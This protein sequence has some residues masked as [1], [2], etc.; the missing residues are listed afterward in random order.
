MQCTARSVAAPPALYATGAAS[1]TFWSIYKSIPAAGAAMKT[2]SQE[3]IQR[4]AATG[5]WG[6]ETLHGLLARNAGNNPDR[7]ALKD[8][9]DRAELTGSPPRSLS[10]RELEWTL[11][12][13][14][15]SFHNG[16]SSVCKCKYIRVS[17]LKVTIFHRLPIWFLVDRN[18]SP[19]EF[20]V[21]T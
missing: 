12:L 11:K 1:Y 18:S 16:R 10:W 20:K 2:S 7:L 13:S 21:N 17:K 15:A 19:V 9:P 5:H 8:Q 6:E 14:I 3:R 4:E